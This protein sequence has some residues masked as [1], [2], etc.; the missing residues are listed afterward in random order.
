MHD[1]DPGNAE[2]LRT[3]L[4]QQANQLR[5]LANRLRSEVTKRTSDIPSE[6]WRGLARIAFDQLRGRVLDL[7]TRAASGLEEAAIESFRASLTLA[8]RV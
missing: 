8:G 2:V 4:E 3:L 6:E 7:T 1:F 5:D